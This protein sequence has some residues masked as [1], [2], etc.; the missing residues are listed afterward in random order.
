LDISNATFVPSGLPYFHVAQTPTG[1]SPIGIA[2]IIGIIKDEDIGVVIGVQAPS[3]KQLA[4][5]VEA[6]H[7]LRFLPG[8]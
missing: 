4:L 8:A 2:V 1:K 5:V 3:D 6:D 7:A